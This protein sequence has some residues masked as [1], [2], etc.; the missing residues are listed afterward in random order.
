MTT[1]FVEIRNTSARGTDSIAA[2]V[3]RHLH[4]RQHLGKAVVVYEQS[5]GM[6]GAARKQW[7][8]LSRVL[9]KQRAS[10]LN[11]DKILKYT[12]TITHMQ[13]MRFTARAPLDNPEADVYFLPPGELGMVP[14]RCWT[15]YVLDPIDLGI[16]QDM[17]DQLPAQALVVDYDHSLPWQEHF[18][19]EPKAMLEQ[20]VDS[21]WAEVL[22]FLQSHH[23]TV[24]TIGPPGDNHTYTDAMDNSLNALLGISQQFLHVA[25]AFQR[26]LEIARPLQI[27]K[28]LRDAYDP[29]ILLAH[30]V[31]ALSSD[32]LA[33][34][35]L[36]SYNEDDTFFLYDPARDLLPLVAD[37]PKV[38]AR[39]MAAGRPHLA[40]ALRRFAEQR[41]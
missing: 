39:H 34:N 17:L 14:V 36:E 8:K 33:Q 11:A 16:A 28:Q 27:P 19:L 13:H 15:V 1:C 31:Q 6:L 7:L 29:V 30:R 12:H 2:D 24:E 9:Q 5:I 23:I 41:R 38:F 20:Q 3:M 4:A 26:S 37:L 40:M 32:F 10:T 35:F 25:N 18:G 22:Q 21:A